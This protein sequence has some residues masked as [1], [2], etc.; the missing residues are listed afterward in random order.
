MH[1]DSQIRLLRSCELWAKKAGSATRTAQ[2]T[3]LNL[4]YLDIS[5]DTVHDFTKGNTVRAVVEYLGIPPLEIWLIMKKCVG[6]YYV[7]LGHVHQSSPI[8]GLL[9][10]AR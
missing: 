6:V 2:A 3:S 4:P 10:P 1:E 9:Y 7:R 5:N 8:E